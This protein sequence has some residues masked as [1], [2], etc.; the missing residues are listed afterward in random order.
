MSRVGHLLIAVDV[1]AAWIVYTFV[2][3]RLVD[4]YPYPFLDVRKIGY[5]AAFGSTVVDPR[6]GPSGGAPPR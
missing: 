3:G 2:R 5:R 4:W 6:T 1:V